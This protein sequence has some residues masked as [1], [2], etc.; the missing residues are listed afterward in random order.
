MAKSLFR[1]NRRCSGLL[2]HPTSLPGG[3]LGAEAYA[4]ADYL[5]KS[6][7]R[8]WQ[9]LPVTPPGPP[10]GNS[11]YRGDSAFAGSPWVIHVGASLSSRASVK[12]ARRF[13]EKRLRAAFEAFKDYAAL[14]LFARANQQWLDDYAL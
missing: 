1:F 6:G 2:L 9:M 7:Q 3:D 13:R 8:W 11:P 12:Q 4:F 14:K 10:P 5:A